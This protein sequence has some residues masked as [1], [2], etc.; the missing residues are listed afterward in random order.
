MGAVRPNEESFAVN[1]TAGNLEAL[2]ASLL[3][4][5]AAASDE[6]AIEAVRVSALGKKGSV[7]E[8]LKTLGAMSAEERQVKG[9]AIN[10][11]K[12]RVTEALSQ[13]KAE[14]K[15]VA[16]AARLEAEK[17]DVTLP[18]R[19]SP[20]ERGR[21]HPISQ[22]IDEIA[23][24][25]GDLGFSIAEGPDIETDHY[26]FTALNFPEG[27]PAREMHD[28]FFFQPDEKG[29]RKLLRTHTSPVQIRTMERQKPPIRIVIP[30][31]T[32]R[33]DSDA[34]H[35]PM[36]HQVEGLVID[37]TANIANMK[38]VLEEFCK[39]FFEVPSV[40]MRFRPSFFPF[41]EPSLEVDIQCDR[42]RPGEVRFG[43][44]SDWMEILGCGMVHPNV[45]RYGGLDP[46]EYQGFAWGM[47]IDRIAM[48]K[49]GMPDL[50]AFFDADVR[51][52]T[53]Y[54]FR[55]LDLPTLFGGL[56]T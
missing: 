8:M 42:S 40:K 33:Q 25:F 26:N 12:N 32:Y 5:I 18:V 3:A 6:A 27:H 15:D 20:A 34:T 29:E 49:Y 16:I 30:G 45:L 31:K 47:G 24:I 11:L 28:T 38:W 44:G 1:A 22:V 13:R 17:V 52:L 4:E 14:L 2:E 50:R 36:F 51:W 54:G 46:D 37:K 19:Q 56:S 9:P 21:I 7:S 53:H 55:P 10:G 23:A 41:T 35:S 39:A 48:L 43:E